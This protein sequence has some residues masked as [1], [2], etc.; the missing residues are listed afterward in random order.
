[1]DVYIYLHIDT[2]IYIHSLEKPL[3]P[4]PGKTFVAPPKN[5]VLEGDGK[6]ARHGK[7]GVLGVN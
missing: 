7:W 1:M 6:V 4:L 3:S 2:Y 5:P